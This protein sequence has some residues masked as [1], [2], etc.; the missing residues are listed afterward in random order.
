MILGVFI[1]FFGVKIVIGLSKNHYDL[2]LSI[3]T[4]ILSIFTD[5]L[6]FTDI[7]PIFTDI[8]F[9]NS[10]TCAREIKSQNFAK[11]SGIY[12]ISSIFRR[13]YRFSIDFFL[14]RLSVANIYSVPAGILFCDDIS[15]EKTDFFCPYMSQTWLAMC[16]VKTCFVRPEKFQ[17]REKKQ[18][19]NFG[20]K[21]V[22]SVKN[23]K[24]IL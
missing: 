22:I 2:I 9:R 20:N 6:I 13:F 14:N 1:E 23:P 4:D 15:V 11:I 19:R 3:F 5:L 17:F 7:S 8:F 21:I 10:N 12:D 24:F 18:N 16:L